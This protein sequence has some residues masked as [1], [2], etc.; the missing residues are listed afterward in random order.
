MPTADVRDGRV[1][2]G[3][4]DRRPA[5]KDRYIRIVPS[6]TW[7]LSFMDRT[8]VE[9]F[10]TRAEG[11]SEDVLLYTGGP[12]IAKITE[13][14][15]RY[16]RVSELD[17]DLEPRVLGRGDL[18][19]FTLTGPTLLRVHLRFPWSLAVRPATDG[20]L[21]LRGFSTAIEG[22]GSS[23]GGSMTPIC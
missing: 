6:T 14:S 22:A 11:G 21:P 1:A 23:T 12:G 5:W 8:G 3:A 13:G 15:D 17:G 2:R 20:P 19:M 4:F 7:T 9:R 18:P 10:E 16:L